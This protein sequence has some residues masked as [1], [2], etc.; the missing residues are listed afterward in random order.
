MSITIQFLKKDLKATGLRHFLQ[1]FLTEKIV[2]GW[3]SQSTQTF[4]FRRWSSGGDCW[5]LRGVARQSTG[6]T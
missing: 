5:E 3:M 1:K 2:F 4:G 6:G